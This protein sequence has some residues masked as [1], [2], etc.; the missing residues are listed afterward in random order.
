MIQACSNPDCCRRI[1]VRNRD[2]CAKCWARLTPEGRQANAKR[3]REY[4]N[5]AKQHFIEMA[6]VAQRKDSP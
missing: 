2:Y 5:R 6:Q 3:Q 4:A 1:Y